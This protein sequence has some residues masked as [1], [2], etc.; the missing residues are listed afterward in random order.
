MDGEY[1]NISTCSPFS[2]SSDIWLPNQ[3]GNSTKGLINIKNNCNNC[4]LWSH[5]RY[6]IPPKIRSEW[7]TKADK[8]MVN[9]LSYEDI[10]FLFHKKDYCKIQQK[11]NIAS[12]H[13]V[14]KIIQFN[15]F[16][17]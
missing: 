16:M 14:I 11:N 12:I 2:G 9:G 8:K 17:Y 10:D 3:L 5:I 1:M 7:I 4:F 6:L 13:F 15:L